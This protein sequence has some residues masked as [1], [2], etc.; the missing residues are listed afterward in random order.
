MSD[1]RGAPND[2]VMVRRAA[3]GSRLREIRARRHLT[4][5]ELAARAGLNRGFYSEVEN[6]QQNISLDRLWSIAD[7]LDVHIS[8]FFMG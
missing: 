4:Q 2:L 7:A 8:E 5:D 3:L 6:G 1:E